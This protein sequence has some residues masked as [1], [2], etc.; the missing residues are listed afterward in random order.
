MSSNTWIALVRIS[1][2]RG[3]K[4]ERGSEGKEKASVIF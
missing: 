3:D 2:I 4:N 1:T